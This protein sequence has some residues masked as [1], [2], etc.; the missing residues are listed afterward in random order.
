MNIYP[1]DPNGNIT[2]TA[3]TTLTMPATR[4]G[5]VGGTNKSNDDNNTT[6]TTRTVAIKV[7]HPDTRR[8]VERDLALMQHAADLVDTYS[9]AGREDDQPAAGGVNLR[10]SHGEAGRPAH[11]EGYFSAP[12]DITLAVLTMMMMTIPDR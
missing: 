8:L 7:L 3:T 9:A 12:F 6:M 1:P 4:D 2:T 10:V 11:R 5:G